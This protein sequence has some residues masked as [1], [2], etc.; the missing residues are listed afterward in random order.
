MKRIHELLKGKPAK[1]L[2]IQDFDNHQYNYANL[3]TM[4][5]NVAKAL[6]NHG[7]VAGDKVVVISENSAMYAAYLFGISKIDAWSVLVNARQTKTEIETIIKHS[8]AKCALFTSLASQSAKEHAKDFNARSIGE[9]KCGSIICT[10]LYEQKP[11]KLIENGEQVAVLLYTTGTTSAPKGVML[12]HNNLIFN[13][14][15]SATHIGLRED[16]KV[17]GVLPGTHVYC[18][19]SAFL[20]IIFAG[21]SIQF[22]PRFNPKQVLEFLR[23]GITRFPGVPQMFASIIELLDKNN[24][25]LDAPSL[26]NLATGGAPLDPDVKI[27]IEKI[28]KLQLNNGYGITECSP[29][30]AVTKNESPRADVSVGPPV[31]NIQVKINKPNND[32]IG[33]I[34]VRGKNVMKGYYRDSKQTKKV[35]TPEGYFKTG[36]LGYFG[37]DGAL[38]VVGRLKE[39]IIRSGFNVFPPEVEAMLTKH[40][41]I[42]QAAVIGKKI[43][44]NE[45]I[46]AFILTNGEI[47]E[48][49]VKKWLKKHLV[50]YKIPQQIYIVKKFPTAATGKILKNQLTTFYSNLIN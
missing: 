15:N 45:E 13:A 2:A 21:G 6:K 18:L 11:E 20:P 23:N 31:P 14:K 34:F 16:D 33:E 5:S 42:Y 32:N 30:I 7:V 1:S 9:I 27:R 3:R 25:S 29:T 19:A 49:E 36:D 50:S 40:P 44:N 47:T 12:T 48:E 41:S 24:E 4:S 17:L 22:V 37:S 8:K 38:F 28:F 46:L 10:Q 43:N 35:I 39:L 26:R